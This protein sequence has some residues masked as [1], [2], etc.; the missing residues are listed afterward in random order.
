[1]HT[2]IESECTEREARVQDSMR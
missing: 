2:D 1:M